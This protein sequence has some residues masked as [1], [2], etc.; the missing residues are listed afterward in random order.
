MKVKN[1]SKTRTLLL[2]ARALSS[3]FRP[4]FFPLTGFVVLFSFTYMS[5]LPW[6][7]KGIIL[8]MVLMG[9]IL[10][11]RL[12]IR[13]WRQSR[14]WERHLLRLRQN[15]FMPYIIYILYYA[16]TL[17]LLSRFHLPHYLSGLLVASLIIQGT[18]TLINLRWKISMHC[19]G[20]G[21]IT[22]ALVA[23][24]LIFYFNPLGWLSLSIVLS[25]LVG[26]SRMVLRQ[27]TLW[28][29]L[30]GTAVGVVGAFCGILFF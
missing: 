24:S 3:L 17:H 25:G 16:F 14:G 21:G 15:R 12:T 4:E 23:Y 22:G 30:A 6:A 18:C 26:T 13:Y 29:V 5:L 19:A 7:F 28:Q 1:N 8:A 9:T 2:A 10:L 27:H 20:A 11:P